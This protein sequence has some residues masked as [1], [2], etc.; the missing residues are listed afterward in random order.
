M[1][2]WSPV[3]APAPTT[4]GSG[5]DSPSMP[6]RRMRRRPKQDR[7]LRRR[8]CGAP[9]WGGDQGWG[10]EVPHQRR[11]QVLDHLPRPEARSRSRRWP[12]C[13]ARLP[14]WSSGGQALMRAP[15]L[16][17]VWRSAMLRK[18]LIKVI[19]VVRCRWGGVTMAFLDHGLE[20]AH[21]CFM[22]SARVMA[23]PPQPP[24]WTSLSSSRLTLVGDDLAGGLADDKQ[25]ALLGRAAQGVGAEVSPTTRGRWRP[26]DRR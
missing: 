6:S 17:S 11:G 24:A 19:R 3:A 7:H 9:D 26:S 15:L 23:K 25:S 22:C 13:Q 5:P 20:L 16:P 10:R 12:S 21:G 14:P 18:R 8:R 2:G 1:E 4:G